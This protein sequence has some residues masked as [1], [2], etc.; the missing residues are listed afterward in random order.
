VE[1]KELVLQ[2]DVWGEK[3]SGK[4]KTIW[5]IIHNM[6]FLLLLPDAACLT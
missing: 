1:E 3:S 6:I 5:L 2:E 4:G